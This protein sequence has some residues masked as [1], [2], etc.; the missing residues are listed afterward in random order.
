MHWSFESSFIL[1]NLQATPPFL[2]SSLVFI[3]NLTVSVKVYN[4]SSISYIAQ[5]LCYVAESHVAFRESF[6]KLATTIFD[7]KFQQQIN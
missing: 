2:P 4:L 3:C 1:C 7:Q 6:A 5:L